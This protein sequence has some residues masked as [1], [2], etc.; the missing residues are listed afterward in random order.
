MKLKEI[1]ICTD[2][3]EETTFFYREI[4]GL[5][6][7]TYRDSLHIQA[8][9]TLLAFHLTKN[10]EPV[11]HIA[12]DIPNNKLE[13]AHSLLKGQLGILFI[14]EENTD[15]IADFSRWNARS[16]YFRDNNGNILEYITRYD[17]GKTS[18]ET[19]GGKSILN[20]SEIGLVSDDVPQ[21]AEKLR[22]T[23]DVPVYEKQ[24]PH[25]HFTAMGDDEGLFIL[26][27]TGRDWYPTKQ[28]SNN[29][30]LKVVFTVD[31]TEHTINRGKIR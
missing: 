2:H 29:F 7:K 6:V 17:R 28:K 16:F 21:L 30:P 18:E 3:P 24:P 10:T 15:T 31:G 20:I 9:D 25:E 23:Y 26:A 13:E 11:Y 22:S 8:G 27:A 4:L 19:F 14:S 5:P 12:F 1:H